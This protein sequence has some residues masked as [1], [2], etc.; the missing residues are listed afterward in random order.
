MEG[1]TVT[2]G[3]GALEGAIALTPPPEVIENGEDTSA[4]APAPQKKERK[5][6][7]F[8]TTPSRMQGPVKGDD[9]WERWTIGPGGKDVH[10]WERLFEIH[11]I[12]PLGFG[13]IPEDQDT[14]YL[15]DL[16]K[17]KPPQQIV[18]LQAM[19]AAMEEWALGHG[20]SQ[21]WLKDHIT[22]DWSSN[23]VINRESLFDKYSRMWFSSSISYCIAMAIEEGATDIG[24]WGIDLESGEEY[25]A[26]HAGAKHFLDLARLA[27]INLHFPEGCGLI[28]D[29]SPYPDRYETHLA[30]TFEKKFNWL[31]HQMG[32]IEP[33]YEGS[34]METYR[35]EGAL[36]MMRKILGLAA[37]AKAKDGACALDGLV[38]R[39]EGDLPTG[40]QELAQLNQRTGELAANV[41]HL[42]GE[43]SAT[44]FYRRMYTYNFTEPG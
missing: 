44:Q 21:K 36:L 32:Q 16:S 28:R 35:T 43:L 10:G 23:V 42:K 2:N 26:Q 3:S 37:E 14:S 24:C 4:A 40:E 12:W 9:G 13:E 33:Q 6:A 17:V 30:Q 34:R 15:N 38:K 22:G 20:K 5:I 11:Q 31:T 27:G 18:T 7:I 39:I 25:I 1:E 8:G 19:P 41:N 29:L